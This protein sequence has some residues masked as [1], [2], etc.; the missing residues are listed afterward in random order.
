MERPC[1]ENRVGILELRGFSSQC[2]AWLVPS[3]CRVLDGRIWLR[4]LVYVDEANNINFDDKTIAI[5]HAFSKFDCF[6]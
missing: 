4:Y 1:W 2:V 6:N 5:F 3:C